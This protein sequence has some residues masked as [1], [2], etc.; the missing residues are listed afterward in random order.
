MWQKRA[1]QPANMEG[2]LAEQEMYGNGALWRNHKVT[3]KSPAV[4][5]NNSERKF[6]KRQKR[7]F[8]KSFITKNLVKYSGKEILWNEWG[9]FECYI[10]LR[11]DNFKMDFTDNKYSSG[12]GMRSKPLEIDV[13]LELSMTNTMD[14]SNA[15]GK[16]WLSIKGCGGL[17]WSV[18]FQ[19]DMLWLSEAGMGAC[20]WP[21]RPERGSLF[22]EQQLRISLGL[23]ARPICI[24]W[25]WFVPKLSSQ[26]NWLKHHHPFLTT[27]L[28]VE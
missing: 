2:K 15:G 10:G 27:P 8:K 25:W 11:N 13:T 24:L 18:P 23:R 3:L 14:S 1:I 6:K 5:L 20:W 28:P 22:G 7:S 21:M 26:V 12:S 16:K 19:K 9:V 4:D 17:S